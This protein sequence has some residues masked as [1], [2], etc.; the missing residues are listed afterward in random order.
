MN[1]SE[2]KYVYEIESSID[3]DDI[4]DVIKE[5]LKLEEGRLMYFSLSKDDMIEI[6]LPID[7]LK[8]KALEVFAEYDYLTLKFQDLEINVGDSEIN[9]PSKIKLELE[10]IDID[11]IIER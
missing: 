9:I 5:E 6:D 2:I 10:G 3:F 4:I 11:N 8:E 7:Q 1:Q